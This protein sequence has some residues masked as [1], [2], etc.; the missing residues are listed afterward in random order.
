MLKI[1]E[2]SDTAGGTRYGSTLY[3]TGLT[4]GKK[5]AY[6]AEQYEISSGKGNGGNEDGALAIGTYFHK[7]MELYHGGRVDET[8]AIRTSDISDSNAATE[9]FRLFGYYASQINPD[10]YG[11]VVSTEDKIDETHPRWSAVCQAVGGVP[12]TLKPDMVVDCD[13]SAIARLGSRGIALPGPGRYMVDF[14]TRGRRDSLAQ[15][16]Y[17]MDLQVLAYPVA[18][19]AV[20]E[21][22]GEPLVRGMILCEIY[23]TK[24]PDIAFFYVQTATGDALGGLANSLRNSRRLIDAKLPLRGDACFSYNRCCELLEKGLCYGY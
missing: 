21:G 5:A 19:N 2:P 20:A 24:Q 12:F 11:K 17:E 10:Y 7:F 9:A 15:L 1:L 13:D 8:M 14:K 4:C 6:Y 16:K 18:Y 3:K 22:S 23:K